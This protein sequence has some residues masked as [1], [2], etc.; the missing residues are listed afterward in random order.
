V[1]RRFNLLW[2]PPFQPKFRDCNGRENAQKAQKQVGGQSLWRH[3]QPPASRIEIM[4]HQATEPSST[5]H[6]CLLLACFPKAGS[7]FLTLALASLPGFRK[8]SLV[9]SYGRREQE[10]SLQCLLAAQRAGGHFVAQH[11]VRYSDETARLL[12]LFGLHPIVLVRDIYDVVVSI[13]DHLKGGGTVIA[14]AYVP[15]GLPQWADKRIE[16]F[17]SEMIIPWYL[18]FY[19]SWAECAERVEITYEHLIGDPELAVRGICEQTGIIATATEI[20]AAV[21]TARWCQAATRFN[22]GVP[23]RG[24]DLSSRVVSRIQRL[25]GYYSF[26]DLSSLGLCPPRKV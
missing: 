10:L 14:Q 20:R 19:A 8:V 7:S 5:D 13:R 18:N 26:L 15:P 16:E 23:G 4:I 9:P 17:A 1:E 21:Q 25:A 11:H 2:R 12:D 3:R 24:K 22:V 6:R